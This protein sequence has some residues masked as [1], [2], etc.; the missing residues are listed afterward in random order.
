MIRWI[1]IVG[2]LLLLA[3]GAIVGALWL[4]GPFGESSPAP[5]GGDWLVITGGTLIDGTGRAPIEDATIVIR[6]EKIVQIGSGSPVRWPPGARRLDARGAFLLPGLWDTHMHIG[7]SAGGFLTAEEFSER[8]YRLNWQAYLYNGVT[9][10]LEMGGVK[11]ALLGW[12]EEERGGR[13]LAPRIFTVGP[14]FTAP[15]GHPAGTI[16]KGNDWF[17]EHATRRVTDPEEARAEVRR[18]VL[19]DRVDAIKA[20][21]DDRDGQIP[22]LSLE[23]LR[24]LI[25]E[26]HAHGK[27][28]FVHVGTARDALEALRSG[29]DGVE[30]AIGS[31]EALWEEALREAARRD[32]FWTP[33]TAVAEA[34]A[35][36]GDPAYI[37][38]YETAGSVSSAVSASLQDPRGNWHPLDEAA[39]REYRARFR[40]KKEA[41]RA[42]RD[43]GIRVA[44]GTD[45]GIS[46]VFHGLSVHRELEILV[47]AGFTPLEAIV[48]ATRG[49]AEKLGVAE[50]RGT[51]EPGKAADLI[52]LKANPLEDIRN[53]RSIE[54]VIH[55][56]VLYRREEL[57]I[58]D[59]EGEAEG[60]A[61]DRGEGD[62]GVGVEVEVGV[63]ASPP[64]GPVPA[65]DAAEPLSAEEAWAA[66]RRA[67]AL[68]YNAATAEEFLQAGELLRAAEA[69]LLAH[70]KRHPDEAE[71]FYRLAQV[72]LTLGEYSEVDREPWGIAAD[73]RRAR[74][75]FEAAWESAK[76]AVRWDET[77][78]DAHRLVGEA[79]MRLIDYEG[80]GF[81]MTMSGRAKAEVERA[82][83]LDPEDAPAHLALGQWYHFAP[84]MVG[85]NRRKALRLFEKA[86]ERAAT[87]HERFLAHVWLGRALLGAGEPKKAQAHLEKALMIYPNSVWARSWRE[88]AREPRD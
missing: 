79:I 18:L 29:A 1:W 41:L 37:R 83:R 74:R 57:A 61:G 7:G 48:T 10:V 13:L 63:E 55:R 31:D 33:T 4:R 42:M 8:Q 65:P 80:S 17:I 71:A 30:H 81:A 24:A 69:A 88:K 50:E 35:H 75:A 59:S 32:A 62:V 86:L 67:R 72:Q 78:A 51:A 3:G 28:V 9:G 34:L 46:A 38:G 40:A 43:R 47:Q 45:A 56:G 19:E 16:Y 2:L 27:R 15:G 87:D 44:L 52:V 23:V 58:D 77:L 49:A 21:Y 85:G 12:R 73:P 20:V 82:I 76:L 53:T 22:K 68:Y 14:L 60:A 5:D 11:D 70:T 36:W 39:L 84:R 26:A 54:W 64:P 25:E 66:H 6:G